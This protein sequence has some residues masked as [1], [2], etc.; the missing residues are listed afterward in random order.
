[1][2]TSLQDPAWLDAQYNNRARIPEHPQIFARWAKASREARQALEPLLDL[3]YG[4]AEEE[5]LD[6]FPA[7]ARVPRCWCSSTA[8]GGARWTSPT[9]PSSRRPSCGAA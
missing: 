1:M 6:L 9:I 2:S 5:T 8:A 4:P 3:R 7:P